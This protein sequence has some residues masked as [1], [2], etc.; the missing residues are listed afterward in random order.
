MCQSQPLRSEPQSE[1]YETSLPMDLGN[2]EFPLQ[3]R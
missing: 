1:R 3:M 2:T